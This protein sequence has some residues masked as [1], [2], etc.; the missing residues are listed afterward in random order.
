MSL[1]ILIDETHLMNGFIQLIQIKLWSDQIMSY[2]SWAN[3]TIDEIEFCRIGS[4][5]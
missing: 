1:T 3:N 4:A 5:Y 2:L